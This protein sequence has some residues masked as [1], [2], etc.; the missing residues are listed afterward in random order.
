[1]TDKI[2]KSTTPTYNSKFAIGRVSCTKDSFV[3]N[4]VLVI[5]IKFCGKNPT[6]Q[7]AANR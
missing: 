1:M 2:N 3:V 7:V 6:L 5:Q 4:Q